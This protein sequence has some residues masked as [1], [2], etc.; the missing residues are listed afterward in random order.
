M[1]TELSQLLLMF[2]N[3]CEENSENQKINYSGEIIPNFTRK[4]VFELISSH[5][6][7]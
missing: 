5:F 3:I 4:H 6:N 7:L 2:S 1:G